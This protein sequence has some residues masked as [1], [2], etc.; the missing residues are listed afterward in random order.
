[1]A[2]VSVLTVAASTD[3]V[4]LSRLAT[5]ADSQTVDVEIVVASAT[6]P[7]DV[8]GDVPL[9][10]RLDVR[11]VVAPSDAPEELRASALAGAS[12]DVVVW[13]TGSE[14][15]DPTALAVLL[16]AIDAG[17]DAAFCDH[18][19]TA[20]D[21]TVLTSYKPEWSP[22]RLRSH[23]V[24]TPLLMMRRA[25]AIEVGAPAATPPTVAMHELALRLVERS[26]RVDRV[27]QPLVT[28]VESSP[29][30]SEESGT[31]ADRIAVVDA[32]LRRSG[33]DAHAEATDRD[34]IVRVVRRPERHPVVSVVIPTRGAVGEVGG[35][36]RCFV[37]EAVRSLI[38]RSSY[39]ELEFIVVHDAPTPE[40]VLDEL[41]S[42]AGDALVPV[43]FDEPFNFSTKMNV[44]AA[45]SS[46]ELLLLLNDD[47]ELIDPA[48]IEVMVAHL[49]ADDVAM[50]GAKLLFEDGSLQH[51][52]H[53]Y[54]SKIHHA[55]FGWP[56]D[57]PGPAPHFPLAVER[58]CSGVT[59]A[60]ALVRRHDFEAVGGFDESLPL[61]YNDVDLSLK[62]RAE[63][64]RILWT[65]YASWFH[66]ESRTR[67]STLLPEEV[68]LIG[69]R[70]ATELANDPYY[71]PALS[72]DHGDWRTDPPPPTEPA[73]S[74]PRPR[75][76][77]VAGRL[78]RSIR[79]GRR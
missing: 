21:G 62:L 7:I 24:V 10:V 3:S 29:H 34:G 4:R 25:V 20:R 49:E 55:C 43:A 50:V 39:R 67:R 77:R 70:W 37:V 17:A 40:S 78:A 76:R 71:H 27:P 15:W 18:R 66:F 41:R 57:S 33:I 13:S 58:E 68:E 16:A 65:P 74:P 75:W 9:D 14:T 51:G 6:G 38:E 19:S 8:S 61:N 46:G 30:A 26:C 52:G 11:C 72:V 54:H 79:R 23:D 59:A 69:R 12:G 32:H 36:M 44:G 56:G 42:I 47:T 53:V 28:T 22:E 64:H 48:G 2:R 1:M 5:A 73:P 31:V 60:A 35:A 63:G 45:R